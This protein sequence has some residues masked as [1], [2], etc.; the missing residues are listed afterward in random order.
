MSC[1]ITF[2]TCQKHIMFRQF[3]LMLFKHLELILTSAF[4]FSKETHIHESWI[5]DLLMDSVNQT[6]A[7]ER[8]CLKVLSFLL[9]L[10][11]HGKETLES[12]SF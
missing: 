11:V 10:C 12:G 2:V 8:S 3:Q 1:Q 5:Q 7:S 4:L 9:F 6:G